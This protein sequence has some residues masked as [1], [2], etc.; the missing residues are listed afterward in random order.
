MLWVYFYGFSVHKLSPFSCPGSWQPW[1]LHVQ[2][3]LLIGQRPEPTRS[4]LQVHESGQS[5]CHVEL[6]QGVK[7][8]LSPLHMPFCISSSHLTSFPLSPPYRE[9]PLAFTWLLPK[10]GNSWLHSCP[11]LCLVCT[12]ISLTPTWAFARPWPASGMPWSLI[13]PW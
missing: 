5:P 11:S 6:P 8:S 9:Q 2:G 4:C 7:L 3:A 12:A 13:R 1:P 10:P